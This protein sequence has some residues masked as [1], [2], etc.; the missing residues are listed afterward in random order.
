[1]QKEPVFYDLIHWGLLSLTFHEIK[2]LQ[3]LKKTITYE[4]KGMDKEMSK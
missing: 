4:F 2:Y 1:M 3:M